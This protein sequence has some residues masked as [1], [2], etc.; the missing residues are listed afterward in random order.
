MIRFVGLN[1]LVLGILTLIANLGPGAP[2]SPEPGIEF[3]KHIR[4]ILVEHCYQCHGPDSASRKADLRLDQRPA[5][6]ESG[7]IVPGKPDESEFI[8]RI[9]SDS[10][11][12]LMPPEKIHKPLKPEQMELLKRWVAAGA[13]YQQH[14]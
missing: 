2:S 6:M 4:P 13:E 1:A 5:T 3:N 7:V 8:T 9:F 14:S 10:K 11:S 12:K